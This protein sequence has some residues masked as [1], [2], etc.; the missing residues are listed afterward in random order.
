MTGPDIIRQAAESQ[1]GAPYVWG[2][3]GDLCT[4]ALRKKYARL[5]PSKADAIYKRCPV[6]SG[7]QPLCDGC[8]YYGMRAFD[9]RGFTHWCVEM[10]GIPIY[11]QKV[12]VQ[13]DTASNWDV[14]GDIGMMPPG[15]VA[16]VFLDGHTGLYLTGS[17]VIHCSGEVKAEVLGQGRKWT[18]FAV[19]K[20]LYTM[21]QIADAL[22][23]AGMETLRRGSSGQ[24]VMRLQALLNAAG[25][26]CGLID[27]K[28]GA[29][30]ENA[31]RALQEANAVKAD[32]I[33]GPK[34]WELLIKPDVQELAEDDDEIFE[35]ME[36]VGRE[37]TP[38][39]LPTVTLSR[40]DALAIRTALVN[41]ICLID[42]AMRG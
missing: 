22:E 16:C 10:A 42:K 38:E 1:L 14:R 26:D 4:P 18:R 36:D 9:C 7:L 19:P 37:E 15:L 8:K 6:L 32:G 23:G 33:C 12:S 40:E 35:R 3:W 21:K 25:Y 27:G 41:A 2:A 17:E 39:P 24:A 29:K 13:Y 30:T 11:G 28:F 20:G 34:T 5:T 31:V